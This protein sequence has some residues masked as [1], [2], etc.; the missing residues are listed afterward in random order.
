[1]VGA[2][3]VGQTEGR[4]IDG[5]LRSQLR[6]G[7][8]LPG[9]GPV[10]GVPGQ[11]F[12]RFEERQPVSLRGGR[13]PAE[14][15]HGDRR[16]GDHRPGDRQPVPLVPVQLNDVAQPWLQQC[17][18]KSRQVGRRVRPAQP[19]RVGRRLTAAGER[20]PRWSRRLPAEAS[21]AANPHRRHRM[22]G[23][24]PVGRDDP[25]QRGG[26][27]RLGQRGPDHRGEHG[28]QGRRR[29]TAEPQ[30]GV[31]VRCPAARRR[32]PG[33][34]QAAQAG[35]TVGADQR[36]HQRRTAVEPD[37]QDGAAGPGAPVGQPAQQRRTPTGSTPPPPGRSRPT[38]RHRPAPGTATPP[39]SAPRRAGRPGRGPAAGDRPDR[40]RAT[41]GHRSSPARRTTSPTVRRAAVSGAGGVT[42]IGSAGAPT[43]VRSDRR[44]ATSRSDPSG[45][46]AAERLTRG[47]APQ[48]PCGVRRTGPVCTPAD[49]GDRGESGEGDRVV[50]RSLDR[51]AEFHPPIGV[52]RGWAAPRRPA[53]PRGRAGGR[54]RSPGRRGGGSAY[55]TSGGLPARRTPTGGQPRLT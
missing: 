51:P 43:R 39:S 34:L 32:Q 6:E 54:A 7:R 24:A 50:G 27:L 44:R 26:G 13:R 14:A 2:G 53:A 33:D 11:S 52:R 25:E 42:T 55:A 16:T 31:T 17:P 3:Q 47:D 37:G 4:G 38:R 28:Q 8:P 5:A 35:G 20:R 45:M 41:E 36:T 30:L 19:Q 15:R 40:P 21:F 48:G 12:H 10:G 46:G 22:G 9:G 23:H 18:A 1:M 49:R 29:P